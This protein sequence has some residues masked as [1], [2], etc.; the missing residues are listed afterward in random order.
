MKS[1]IAG[2]Q[3]TSEHRI[4]PR[5]A[6]QISR[7]NKYRPL[8]ASEHEREREIR[9][10]TSCVVGRSSERE[11]TQEAEEEDD[12]EYVLCTD[13]GRQLANRPYFKRV[14][15]QR[16][17]IVGQSTSVAGNADVHENNSWSPSKEDRAKAG[18]S[19]M[20]IN[21]H[22][23]RSA[24]ELGGQSTLVAGGLQ[25]SVGIAFPARRGDS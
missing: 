18:T 1:K 5:S 22:S 20:R 10:T 25:K 21:M 13:A 4:L 3:A 19:S 16:R 6:Y 2:E 23:M 15:K 24:C 14:R 11:A 7:G 8:R 12:Y 9:D 17:E